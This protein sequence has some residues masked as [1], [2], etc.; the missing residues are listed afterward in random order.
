MAIGKEFLRDTP[1]VL[2]I[3]NIRHDIVNPAVVACR[4]ITAHNKCSSP[5]PY[6]LIYTTVRFYVAGLN[7]FS[8]TIV[9]FHDI[10]RF[11]CQVHIDKK[12]RN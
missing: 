10:L 2:S 7:C 6:P 4:L 3:S 11:F 12:G 5:R 9:K 8:F 1:R